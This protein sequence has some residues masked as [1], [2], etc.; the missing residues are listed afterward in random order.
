MQVFKRRFRHQRTRT[1]G[2]LQ[3]RI[4]LVLVEPMIKLRMRLC[5]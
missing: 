4:I 3:E 1:T 5:P 2:T